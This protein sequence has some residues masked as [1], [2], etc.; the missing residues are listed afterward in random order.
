M[1]EHTI[2]HGYFSALTIY[3]TGRERCSSGHSFGPAIRTH[4]L[5]HFIYRGKGYYYRKNKKYELREGDAFLILPGETTLYEADKKDPWEY[6]WI[7]FDGYEARGIL[8]NCGLSEEELI[9]HSRQ[10]EKLLNAVTSLVNEFPA[11]AH[12]RYRLLSSIFHVFSYMETSST[13]P[14]AYEKE[15][16]SKALQYIQNNYSYDIKINDLAKY[17]GIDRTYLYKIFKR[18]EHTSPL[19][20]LLNY[21]INEAMKLLE[22]TDFT[23]TEIA[24]SCGFKDSSSFCTHFKHSTGIS[25][26]QYRKAERNSSHHK[27][28]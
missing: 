15:H 2:E 18:S 21:R 10:P 24:L 8:K 20:Y 12:S 4:Y 14:A 22:Q 11:S 28:M 6:A 13:A 1:A 9:Y 26:L 5:I 7:A 16:L 19:Q 23:I 3:Y 25:P 17:M 27:T